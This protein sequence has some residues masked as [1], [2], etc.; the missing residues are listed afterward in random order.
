MNAEHPVA[1]SEY[2]LCDTPPTLSVLLH[3]EP[4]AIPESQLHRKLLQWSWL[5]M[6]SITQKYHLYSSFLKKTTNQPT[7]QTKAPHCFLNFW[8]AALKSI[9]SI[10]FAVVVHHWSLWGIWPGSSFAWV[11]LCGAQRHHQKILSDLGS[12]SRYAAEATK[13]P[14]AEQF[15]REQWKHWDFICNLTH[16]PM[17]WVLLL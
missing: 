2:V 12:H 10:L 1:I 17:K 15:F 14:D 9:S 6:K 13:W 11:G 7:K 5:C 16:C 3:A 4:A 8:G